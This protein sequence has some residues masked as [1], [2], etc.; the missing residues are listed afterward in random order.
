ML[1][2]GALVLLLGHIKRLAWKRQCLCQTGTVR[3]SEHRKGA[4]CLDT[5]SSHF[6][7][8]Y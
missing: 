6:A 4:W 7:S 8:F 5:V 2:T 3:P 1:G